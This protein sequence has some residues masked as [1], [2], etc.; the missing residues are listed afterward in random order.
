M[1]KLNY[2][3]VT[4]AFCHIFSAFSD[5]A[6]YNSSHFGDELK[7]LL[8]D[9]DLLDDFSPRLQ[10]LC[11]EESSTFWL[12]DDCLV[13]FSKEDLIPTKDNG[14]FES[15]ACGDDEWIM[16]IF[17]EGENLPSNAVRVNTITEDWVELVPMPSLQPEGCMYTTIHE[18]DVDTAKIKEYLLE[19][20][21]GTTI[22]AT[23]E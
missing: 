9:D 22:P 13:R 19:G 1:A 5:V 17:Q 7:N 6:Y 11:G 18:T 10:N 20:T 15:D 3:F 2:L 14:I 12:G 4:I 21:N 23:S 16:I 8:V